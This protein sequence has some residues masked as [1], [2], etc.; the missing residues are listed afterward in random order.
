MKRK[1]SRSLALSRLAV[2]GG[3]PTGCPG[4]TVARNIT[5]APKNGRT[6]T[7]L[8]IPIELGGISHLACACDESLEELVR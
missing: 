7:P 5:T 8:G 1:L 2:N 3:V 6:P 4:G